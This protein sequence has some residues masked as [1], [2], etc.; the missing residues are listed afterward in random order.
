MKFFF[1][2]ERDKFTKE[3]PRHIYLQKEH[4]G[5][6]DIGGYLRTNTEHT[7]KK[8]DGGIYGYVIWSPDTK[9]IWGRRRFHLTRIGFS[10]ALFI[11]G[12]TLYT[13][14]C[15]CKKDKM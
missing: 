8:K 15:Q 3:E 5:P 7:N 14:M 6:T 11:L 9:K 2:F 10:F 13:E 12:F 1:R 4:L